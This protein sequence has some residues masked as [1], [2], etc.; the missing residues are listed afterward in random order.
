MMGTPRGGVLL[1]IDWSGSR[2][3]DWKNV[4][5]PLRGA[6]KLGP[7]GRRTS[8]SPTKGLSFSRVGVHPASRVKLS[9]KL[10]QVKV[11]VM[12]LS[13]NIAKAGVAIGGQE[14]RPEPV[15]VKYILS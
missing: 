1:D 13:G 14:A 9:V 12:Q 8:K 4:S 6:Q 3:N 15:S 5:L 7:P 2:P 10:S 11:S